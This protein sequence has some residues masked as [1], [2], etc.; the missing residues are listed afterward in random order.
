MLKKR[1]MPRFLDQCDGIILSTAQ[2]YET[3]AIAEITDWFAETSRQ[4]YTFG[5][6]LPDTST[7]AAQE[8]TLSGRSE[9]IVRFLEKA[10]ETDGP[11]SL[12]YVCCNFNTHVL[13]AL[14]LFFLQISF[15][16]VFWSTQPEKIW[17]FLDVVIERKI[18]FVCQRRFTP[19]PMSQP[20]HYS[21]LQSRFSICCYS[22]RDPS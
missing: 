6:L 12:L 10:L 7:S 4:V 21:D 22:R 3:E 1:P 2:P 14:N 18:P 8:E 16:S 20:V 9:E 19:V 17:A 11:N 15:G 5:H 13:E